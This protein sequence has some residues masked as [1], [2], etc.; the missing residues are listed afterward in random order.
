MLFQHWQFYVIL[1]QVFFHLPVIATVFD[2]L[3]SGEPGMMR[4]ITFACHALS[5][6]QPI[7]CLEYW[8]GVVVWV[9]C[10]WPMSA[11]LKAKLRCFHSIQHII[12]EQFWIHRI[13]PWSK[14]YVRRPASNIAHNCIQLWAV[15]GDMGKCTGKPNSKDS[16]T[17][18]LS[19]VW[20]L[21]VDHC[22]IQS[23]WGSLY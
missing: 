17:D 9:A 21:T 8:F 7:I 13:N 3:L 23:V 10:P 18:W 11:Q 22:L 15:H 16:V 12:S 5:E 20:P 2:V 19:T 6:S 1:M 14:R 4:G